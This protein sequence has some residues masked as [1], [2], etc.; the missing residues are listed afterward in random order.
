MSDIPSKQP[1]ADLTSSVS[2]I[3]NSFVSNGYFNAVSEDAGGLASEFLGAIQLPHTKLTPQG[4]GLID[5]LSN[6]RWCNPATDFSE[7]PNIYA[8]ELQLDYGA[9]TQNLLNVFN[10]IKNLTHIGQAGAS[11]SFGG[12]NKLDSYLQLYRASQTGFWYNFPWLVS[13]GDNIR[14]VSSSWSEVGINPLSIFDGGKKTKSFDFGQIFGAGLGLASAGVGFEQV[15]Q[16]TSTETQSITIKFPLY[17]TYSTTDAFNNYSF[18]SLFTFQNL[19]TR[20]SFM[21]YIPPKLYTLDSQALGGIY[22]PIAYVS[23][24]KIDSI[25]TTRSMSASQGYG[26]N[27]I[28]PEAYRV[29]IT[30][31]ELLPQSSNIFE[32]T[33]G[34][35]KINVSGTGS[36]PNPTAPSK[37]DI[38]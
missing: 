28:V 34:G 12:F 10:D 35:S 18:V 1:E 16:Y 9:W 31:K 26:T 4:N 30:F 3:N 14:E 24:L 22:W 6:H 7:V 32:G 11:T 36:N 21:T 15:Q 23:N 37:K 17:N 29:S 19:K 13:D 27:I 5:I 33:I 8:T 38:K 2:G 20:T 25:G